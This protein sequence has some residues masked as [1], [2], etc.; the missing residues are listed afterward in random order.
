M[1]LA[2]RGTHTQGEPHASRLTRRNVLAG[3]AVAAA[4]GIGIGIGAG[5]ASHT[6]VKTVSVT[7]NV[8]VPGP[9]V[10]KTR[11]VTKNVPGPTVY[12]VR[13]VP[14][15]QGP[16]GTVVASYAGSGNQNTGPFDVPSSGDYVVK[17]SYSGNT[18][19]SIGGAANF[20]VSNTG[21][22]LGDGLPNDIQ[23]SGSGSTEVTGG[24]GTDSF[25]VQAT[26]QW[27][28]TVT[29]AP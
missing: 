3:A 22:G 8:P 20:I 24:S 5:A 15:S 14:A 2:N 18:D 19:P 7:R 28:I 11:T 23:S 16:T 26:G 4:L 10:Y 25:N 21:N 29:S 9:T 12:K 13:Y 1:K 17:W 27:T 6:T